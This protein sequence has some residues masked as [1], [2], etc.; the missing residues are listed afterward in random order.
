MRRPPGS[1]EA[2]THST[3]EDRAAADAGLADALHSAAIHLLR[4]VRTEDARTGLTP[5]RL[6]ALSVV[7]YAGPVSLGTLAEAEGVRSPTMTGIVRG[8]ESAGLVRRRNDPL[9]HRAVVIATTPKGRR[10]LSVARARR[11]HLLERL[12]HP[13]SPSERRTLHDAV[14]ILT[15]R[16]ERADSDR[17]ASP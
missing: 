3:G 14:R 6:S 11:L 10:L 4:R 2:S 15:E 9:D 13:L 17:A 8:L 1:V 5:A 12:L 7:V 16:M